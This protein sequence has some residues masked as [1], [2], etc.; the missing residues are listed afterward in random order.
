[1]TYNVF[2]GTLN[3]THSL[4]LVTQ[5]KYALRTLTST[6]C[7]YARQKCYF[8]P[9][10]HDTTC[11]QAGCQ[12]GFWQPAVSCIQ[13]VDNRLNEQWLF[14]QHGCQTGC[15]TDC[16]VWQPV[17]QP[18]GCLFTRYSRL[19]NR[20]YNRFDNRL[21]RV[22]GVL[23]WKRKRSGDIIRNHSLSNPYPLLASW[24]TGVLWSCTAV[25]CS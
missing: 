7:R 5:L 13:P 9:R 17:W 23:S 3:H 25:D 10:L 2:S 4:A 21:Y 8:K 6:K 22:N 15:Q 16:S 12:S 11:C 20:L 1:M 24:P 19:S 14:V 18:V